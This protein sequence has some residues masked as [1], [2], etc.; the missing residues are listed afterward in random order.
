M[1]KLKTLEIALLTMD[2]HYDFTLNTDWSGNHTKEEIK[3]SHWNKCFS[4][5]MN[6]RLDAYIDLREEIKL[7]KKEKHPYVHSVVDKMK[8][9]II[10]E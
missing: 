2:A 3:E 5:E 9:S 8:Y 4:P 10:D 1:I 6:E 7:L